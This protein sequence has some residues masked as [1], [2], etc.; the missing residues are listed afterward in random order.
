MINIYIYPI[1]SMYDIFTYK[2]GLYLGQ[3]QML[4]NIPAPGSHMG[5]YLYIYIIIHCLH[6]G[7]LLINMQ[8]IQD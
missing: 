1:C 5:I 8:D 6:V 4:V 3:R 2:T 7:Q